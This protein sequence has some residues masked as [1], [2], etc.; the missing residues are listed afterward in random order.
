[1]C[2][3]KKLLLILPQWLSIRSYKA[4][5]NFVYF[6]KAM[7]NHGFVEWTNFRIMNYVLEKNPKNASH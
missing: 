5:H 3:K 4:W 6:Q 1:M 2:I 7:T